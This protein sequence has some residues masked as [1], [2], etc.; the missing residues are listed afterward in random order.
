MCFQDFTTL[1]ASVP[2]FSISSSTVSPGLTHLSSS[3]PQ[4][5][6]TVYGPD[7]TAKRLETWKD[8]K[9]YGNQNGLQIEDRYKDI[10]WDLWQ[11]RRRAAG[12]S[13]EM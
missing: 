9:E 10:D 12:K 6:V 2:I 3:R 4:P 11:E 13:D 5:P 1:F 7:G 8:M